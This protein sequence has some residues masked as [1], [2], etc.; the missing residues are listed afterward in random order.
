[1]YD[2]LIKNGL[3]I[4]GLGEKPYRA[5][6]AVQDDRICTLAPV[7]DEGLSRRLIDAS[8]CVVAPGFIDIHSH[9]DFTFLTDPKADSKIRQGITTEVVG[10]CGFTAAPVR[11]EHFDEL[12]QYLVNTV[13]VRDEEEWRWCW[14][15]QD[16]YLREVANGKIAV[17][18]ASLVGHGTIRIAVMG[19]AHRRPIELE[20]REMGQLLEAELKNGLWGLSTGLQYEPGS[21]AEIEELVCL[22]RLVAHYGG[23]YTTHLKSEGRDL[24]ECITRAVEIGRQSGVSVLISH[25]KASHQANWGKA[26]E[27][28]EMIDRAR[29]EGVAVDFDVYPYTAYGSGLI[30]LVPP[31]VREGGAGKMLEILSDRRNHPRIVAEM[32]QD[33]V[34]WE[35]P[36]CDADWEAVNIA[37]VKTKENMIYEGKNLLELGELMGCSPAEAVLELLL[38]ESGVVK[39][40]VF[41]MCEKD[42]EQFLIHPRAIFCTDGRAVDPD[43]TMGRSKIHPRYYGAFPRILGHYVRDKQ[44]ISL[45]EAVKKMTAGPAVKLGLNNRGLIQQGYYADITIFNP[46]DVLDM[47]TFDQP[48]CYPEG[49]M[50][51]IVNGMVAVTPKGYNGASSGRILYRH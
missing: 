29:S 25:L 16:D 35:N 11:A 30:D 45:E 36:I 39:T 28:L 15:S 23:I 32:A 10:N 37:S 14:S 49:I 41:A 18:V 22:G 3:I 42:L 27:A 21:F 26:K 4:D 13:A 24:L 17:N 50:Y 47:A 7:I 43:G 33:S 48:H 2:L 44:L 20:Q 8:G 51:V 5:D 19:F 1:M 6:L 12:M 9:T 31:W 40:V 46:R 38:A 34:E